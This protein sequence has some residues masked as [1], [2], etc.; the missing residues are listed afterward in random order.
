MEFSNTKENLE[1]VGENEKKIPKN[2]G[3]CGRNSEISGQIRKENFK[4]G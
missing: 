3:E 1:Y 2:V 4:C